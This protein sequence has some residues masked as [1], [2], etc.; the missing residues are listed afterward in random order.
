MK[1]PLCGC[2]D[3]HDR[4]CSMK[5]K[6]NAKL[7][8]DQEKR[9]KLNHQKLI[10]DMRKLDVNTQISVGIKKGKTNE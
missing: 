1:C 10:K 9:R 4:Q 7:L 8:R 2:V 3:K 5:N 6:R